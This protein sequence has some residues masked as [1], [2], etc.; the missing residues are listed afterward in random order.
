LISKEH[1]ES[2]EGSM[3]RHSGLRSR[4]LSLFGKMTSAAS[5]VSIR[6]NTLENS[7]KKRIFLKP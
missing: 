6:M 2:V 3:E 7:W 5:G 4:S 1:L